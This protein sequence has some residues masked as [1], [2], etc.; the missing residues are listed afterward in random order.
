MNSNDPTPVVIIND[1]PIPIP[2]PPPPIPP[3][4]PIGTI[5]SDQ[6][7]R[8]RTGEIK[9]TSSKEGREG[10]KGEGENVTRSCWEGIAEG[11]ST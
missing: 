3:T 5:C 9:D 8:T 6:S 10:E 2:T 7:P 11:W 4:L 1:I